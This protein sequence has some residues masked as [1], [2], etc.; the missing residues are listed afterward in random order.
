MKLTK[1]WIGHRF[2]PF[3]VRLDEARLRLFAKAIGESNPIYTEPA[4]AREAG[5]RGL[6]MP[7]TYAFCLGKDIPDPADVLHLLGIDYAA[8]LHGEQAFHYHAAAC[9]GDVLDGT[10]MITDI[11]ERKAGALGFVALETRFSQ[12]TGEA[13]CEAFQ[14]IVVRGAATP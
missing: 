12:A 11:Y 7:P 2:P 9:A 8:V 6:P 5:Y 10:K 13:V 14:T 4:A 1:A 3:Q